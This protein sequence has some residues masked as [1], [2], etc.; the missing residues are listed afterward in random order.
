MLSRGTALASIL[1]LAAPVCGQSDEFGA[2]KTLF[3]GKDLSGWK[4]AKEDQAGGKNLWLVEDGAMTNGGANDIC[5]AEEFGSYELE[6]EFKLPPQHGNSGVYLRGQ[7]EVQVAD[8]YGKTEKFGQGD[9]GAIYS[10]AEP[11]AMPKKAENGWNR[12]R[13][14]HVGNH[15]TV[16]HNDTL[17]QDNPWCDHATGGAMPTLKSLDRGPLMLQGDHSKI[18]YRNIRIRPLFGDGWKAIWNGKD[19]SGFNEGGGKKPEKWLVEKNSFT[20]VSKGVHDIWTDEKFG[21]FLVHYAYRAD[22]DRK[23]EFGNSGFYLRD[24]WEI[25]ILAE[26]STKGAGSDGALYSIK[27]PA[28]LAS[29]GPGQW[30]HMD[31]KVQGMKIWVW[32]NGKLIHDGVVLKTRT[33]NHSVKTEKFS[34]A[35]FKFQGDHGKVWF[36]DLWIKTLPDGE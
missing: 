11:L 12:F 9:C 16:Y 27:P 19:L 15:V 10:V 6:I 8:S 1:F 13:I 25:Q 34:K 28:V 14:L 7:V 24:Q 32:Q 20:N 36:T 17:V 31:V 35:P 3:N 30:N 22:P 29:N 4:A 18:W 26:Q 21:N 33:D 2:W 23:Q 5:T